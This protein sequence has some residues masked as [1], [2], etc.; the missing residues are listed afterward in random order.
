MSESADF[1]CPQRVAGGQHLSALAFAV[2]ISFFAALQMRQN[3][4]QLGG[5]IVFIDRK[6]KLLCFG[7]SQHRQRVIVTREAFVFFAGSGRGFFQPG[8]R[9]FDGRS[10]L[11][12]SYFFS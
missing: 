3:V 12:L 5:E 4:L 10:N 9:L 8:N 1:Q 2:Q 11:L 7:Q 6:T